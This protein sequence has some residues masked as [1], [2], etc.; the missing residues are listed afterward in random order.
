MEGNSI[1]VSDGHLGVHLETTILSRAQVLSGK[2]QSLD[3]VSACNAAPEILK[4]PN[5]HRMST[6]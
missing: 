4:L 2:V 6:E 1:V 5:E 3:A